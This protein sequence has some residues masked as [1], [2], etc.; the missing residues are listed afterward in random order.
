MTIKSNTF[1]SVN[2]FVNPAN[3]LTP[4][5][6]LPDTLN[7]L[8]ADNVRVFLK[9]QTFLPLMNIKCLPVYSMLSGAPDRRRDMVEAS[10]GNTAFSMAIL[11]PMM[12]FGRVKSLV[13]P[14]VNRQKIRALLI[15][16]SEVEVHERP[17]PLAKDMGRAGVWQNLNQYGNMDNVRGHQENTAPQ[18]WEQLDGN[19]QLFG[20]SLGTTGSLTGV[21]NFLRAR[22]PVKLIGIVGTE[23][24][25]IPGPRR[26]SGLNVV[27][28]PWRDLVDDVVQVETTE[29]YR[30]SLELI[31]NGLLVG[32]SS[33]ENVIGTIKYLAKAKAEGELDA[34]R[35]PDGV[36]NAVTLACDT[37]FPYIDE[38][39]E[40]LPADLFPGTA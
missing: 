32:P 3:H 27:D 4:L 31:R 6:Q 39:F 12:G 37:Y 17:I 29:A 36:I 15:A 28:I 1:F 35:G 33:G 20:S 38:Y 11:A 8:A 14:D 25:N 9:M 2:D 34:L 5:V 13:A 24:S 19:I 16:G 21:G 22:A 26:L 7:P 30:T 10:S 18:I 40:I 23:D